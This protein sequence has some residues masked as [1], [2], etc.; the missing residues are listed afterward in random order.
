MVRPI[1]A[2][3]LAALLTAS[4]AA[5]DVFT[6]DKSHSEVSF[7]VRHMM[8]RVSGSFG[9]FGGTIDLD[10]AAPERSSVEFRIQAASIDTNNDRRDDHLRGEDFFH[11]EQH[12]EIVFKSTRVVPKGETTF[13]VHGDLTM[14]GVTKPI[15][16]PVTFLGTMTDGRGQTKAGWETAVTLSRK[17][18][19]IVWNRALD[20]GGLV[21]GDEVEVTINLQAASAPPAATR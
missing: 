1:V 19:G 6:V 3:V 14:R 7:R 16:L 11:V 13:E 10:A 4:S 9:D 18:F 17:D 20:T 8:S 21:L 15:V 5:A 12:P 2:A